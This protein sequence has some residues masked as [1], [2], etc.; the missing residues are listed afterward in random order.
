MQKL[1]DLEEK[2]NNMFHVL[3]MKKLILSYCSL[4]GNTFAL[5]P[6]TLVQTQVQADTAQMTTQNAVPLSL[7]PIPSGRLKIS[8]TVINGHP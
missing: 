5:E 3:S 1:L 2:P 4:F 6:R 8:R 7:D